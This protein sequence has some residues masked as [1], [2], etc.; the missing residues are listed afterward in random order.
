MQSHNFNV[1]IADTNEGNIVSA[2]PTENASSMTQIAAP[3]SWW[4]LCQAQYGPCRTP[5][6]CCTS[7]EGGGLSSAHTGCERIRLNSK[8]NCWCDS[9][10][11]GLCGGGSGTYRWRISCECHV[12]CLYFW[13]WDLTSVTEMSTKVNIGLAQQ[14]LSAVR[15]ARS[16]GNGKSCTI[17]RGPLQ[18]HLIW[19]SLVRFHFSFHSPYFFYS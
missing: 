5:Y 3:Q 9:A 13:C 8:R 14:V 2:A 10:A 19:R 16:L 17:K 4:C 1:A 15:Q 12:T 11:H 7:I 18:W 6:S